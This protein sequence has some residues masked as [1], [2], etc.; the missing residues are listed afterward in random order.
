VTP[1]PNAEPPSYPNPRGTVVLA[2]FPKQ[3]KKESGMNPPNRR[4]LAVLALLVGLAVF[5]G[6]AVIVS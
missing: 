4:H 5:A 1:V 6:R 3:E 2:K